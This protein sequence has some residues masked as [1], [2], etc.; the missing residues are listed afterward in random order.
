MAKTHILA[1]KVGGWLISVLATWDLVLKIC[2][3]DTHRT[4]RILAAGWEGVV[5]LEPTFGTPKLTSRVKN[6]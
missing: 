4:P 5:D 2:G 1:K 6:V 3:S